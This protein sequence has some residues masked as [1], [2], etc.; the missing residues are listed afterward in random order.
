MFI[1]VLPYKQWSYSENVSEYRELVIDLLHPTQ[2]RC[3]LWRAGP[4]VNGSSMNTA[5][6]ASIFPN[7]WTNFNASP[8]TYPLLTE[9]G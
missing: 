6:P 2:R 8:V 5:S 9:Y 4:K 7:N 3:E 1:Y